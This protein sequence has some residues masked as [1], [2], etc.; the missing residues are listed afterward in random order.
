MSGAV[1]VVTVDHERTSTRYVPNGNVP[2][3]KVDS[4][5]RRWVVNKV[6]SRICGSARPQRQ[7]QVYDLNCTTVGRLCVLVGGLV[8]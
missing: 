4:Y 3:G 1:S 7:D 5:K 2:N 8:G 6:G